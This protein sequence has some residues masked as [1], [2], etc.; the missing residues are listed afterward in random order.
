MPL[1]GEQIFRKGLIE[2]PVDGGFRAASYDLHVGTILVAPKEDKR[3]LGSGLDD[4]CVC[5]AGFLL[6][7]QGMVRVISR[8]SVKLPKNIVGYALTK[9]G[10]SN[11]GILA[12]NIGI[13]DPGYEGPIS[14][15]LINFGKRTY[16]VTPE[17]SFLRLTFHEI[18]ETSKVKPECHTSAMYLK[19]TKREV[20]RSS[21]QKFLNL[22][23]LAEEAGQEA[24]GRFKK[25]LF[26]GLP[27][28]A[29][30]LTLI[31]LCI[32]LGEHVWAGWNR[33][34]QAGPS[35]YGKKLE[36]TENKIGDI[37]ERLNAAESNQPGPVND[38]TGQ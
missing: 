2:N 32:P 38:P 10:L 34:L 12:I 15:T 30:A 27:I 13:I 17:T 20:L 23:E 22:S 6:P 35:D 26:L 25:L 3:F 11:E 18:N 1:V 37:E 29:L 31:T 19:K 8:E 7:P 16:E 33:Y 14:S 21:G 36:A 28:A 9:N 24:F 5:E 4:I